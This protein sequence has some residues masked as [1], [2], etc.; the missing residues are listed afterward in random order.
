VAL[1]EGGD[2]ARDETQVEGVRG[3]D[4]QLARHL[5][6]VLAQGAQAQ[7]DLVQGLGAV[8]QKLVARTG[9]R[10]ALAC[11][12]EQRRADLL[13]ELLDLVR[14]RRLRD[15]QPLGRAREVERA[16]QCDE[17]AQV[18]QFHGGATGS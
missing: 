7:V 1:V 5:R 12:V 6:A 10:H 8:V 15:M 11:A 3:A 13:F 17:V 18:P 16:G 4:V 9:Q 2:A 14:Q